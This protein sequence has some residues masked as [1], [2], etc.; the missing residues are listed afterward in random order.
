MLLNFLR[1][2]PTIETWVVRSRY[3]CLTRIVKTSGRRRTKE[4]FPVKGG[5]EEQSHME[6][7]PQHSKRSE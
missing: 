1:V 2:L 6:E 7:G 5:K 3:I 4:Y